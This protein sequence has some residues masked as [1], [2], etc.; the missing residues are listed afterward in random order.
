MAKLD[1]PAKIPRLDPIAPRPLTSHGMG[2]DS[3]PDVPSRL[4]G[5]H[6]LRPSV[7][8]Q[9]ATECGDEALMDEAAS[10]LRGPARRSRWCLPVLALLAS[11]CSPFVGT[12]ARSFLGHVRNN[13]DPNIRFVAYSKL[14]SPDVYDSA[15]QKDE[16]VRTLIE[17]YNERPRAGRHQSD[18]LPDARRAPRSE[19]AGTSWS[20]RPAAPSPSSRSR[21]AGPSARSAVPRMRRSCA[22]VMTLDNLEDARIAAIDGLAEMKTADP[23]I[24]TLLVDGM[25]HDDPGHPAGLVERTPQ[26]CGQGPR[27]GHRRLAQ[28]D[29]DRIRRREAPDREGGSGRRRHAV[30]GAEARSLSVAP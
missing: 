8:D 13:P 19:C 18:D 14:G 9:S 1:S 2:N 3:D 11:G 16:A 20:R 29:E 15:E 24:Q 23:R 27:H 12:T 6:G 22:Q 25:E 17:K 7:L 5:S 28:G 26:D 10:S 30:H 21:P 4:H